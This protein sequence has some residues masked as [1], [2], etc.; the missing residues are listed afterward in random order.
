MKTTTF[1]LIAA[2]VSTLGAIAAMVLVDREPEAPASRP[3]ASATN[4]ID[5]K[6][7]AIVER[8]PCF[9]TEGPDVGAM[10]DPD[11]SVP[12][13]VDHGTYDECRQLLTVAGA[14]N[15]CLVTSG[16]QAGLVYSR[17]SAGSAGPDIAHWSPRT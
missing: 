3:P 17:G 10:V 14:A 13:R 7:R 9:V 4:V 5:C 2:T 16:N 15:E 11:G 6:T 1:G 12:T 8:V